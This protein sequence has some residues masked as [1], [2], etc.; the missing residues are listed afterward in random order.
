MQATMELVDRQQ[1]ISWKLPRDWHIVL[2]NNPD[3]GDYSVTSLDNA[4]T[5]RYI[6]TSLKFDIDCWAKWAESQ[7]IDTRCINFLLM[8]PELVTKDTNARSITN[9]FNAISSL[10]SFDKSLALIQL[11]GE[12]S[13]GNEFASMFVLFIN[14]KLDKLLSPKDILFADE[15]H[16][17]K[18]LKSS[19]GSGANY[20]ADIAS[21][22]ATRMVNY[23][24][25]YSQENN[26]DKSLVERIATIVKE[27]VFTNDLKYNVV[28]GIFN[29]NKVK[30][31]GLTMDKDLVK[32]VLA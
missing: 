18:T 2:S 29:G 27:E 9:F 21:V 11:I 23:S 30:F 10:E 6:S 5:T 22:I 24:V 7:Q 17:L 15:A 12:G 26:V 13:V 31:K 28:K 1:Y 4:Q 14:N 8:H 25:H 3:N 32:F 19:I 20:R 16:V